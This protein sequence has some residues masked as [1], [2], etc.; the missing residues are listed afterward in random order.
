[1][2][3]KSSRPYFSKKSINFILKEFKK[4]LEEGK[5][6]SQAYF[7][8]K[9]ENE[10]ASYN[11][12]RYAISTSSGTSALELIIRSLKIENSEIILPAN[13]FA[14]TAFAVIRSGNKPIFA[15]IASDMTLDPDDVIKRIN[16]KT[17]AVITVHIG[18]I[19]SP[20]TS[21]LSSLC[22]RK[23]I[24]L[25]EDSAHA[26]GSMLDGKKAGSFGDA[27]AFSFFST[28]VMT[29]G[30]GGMI[31]TDNIM[32][33]NRACILR[34]QAK[35]KHKSYEN[36]HE[37]IGYN[38]RMT[39]VQALMGIAQLQELDNLIEKRI[40]IAMIYDEILSNEPT[41]KLIP[42]PEGARYNYYKYIVFLPVG[43]SRNKLKDM[44]EKKGI[45]LSGYVYEIPLHKQPVFKKFLQYNLPSAEKL[46]KRHIC[47]PLHPSM[48]GK[49]ARYTGENL[50]ECLKKISGK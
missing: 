2:Q 9:F 46:C 21:K 1:M 25:I 39:E 11:G 6:L 35:K 33:R 8:K 27:A 14:A 47:L 44:L 20:L 32:I 19:I 40:R 28:K 16:K 5:F 49:E 45:H 34:N 48:S 31:A 13:T 29:C 12:S 50:I 23:G 4:I 38:F 37:E 30:E 36:Y 22:K 43:I 3:I 24:Y 26:H 41:I 17:S 7:C 10:F 42:H 15:D 18:G